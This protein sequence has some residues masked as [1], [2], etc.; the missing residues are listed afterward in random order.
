MGCAG[1]FARR[2]QQLLGEE[3]VALRTGEQLLDQ[4]VVRRRLENRRQLLGELAA[5]ERRQLQ[6]LDRRQ[7]LDLAQE[8]PQRM[9]AVK[10]VAAVG[11][12][13]Q[14]PL[15]AD[16]AHQEREKPARGGIG[17]MQILNHQ[18]DRRF[19]PGAREQVHQ[20]LEQPRLRQ[21]IHGLAPNAAGLQ[22]GQQP[23][24]L[25]TPRADELL[26]QTRLR[27]PD[28]RSERAQQR[29][30]GQLRAADV[31]T[32]TG[33]D[34][35][36]ARAGEPLEL[37]EQARLPDARL[38]AD[39]HRAGLPARPRGPALPPQ[40]RAAHSCQQTPDLIRAFPSA[41]F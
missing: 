3:R 15:P 6:R 18:H 21:R 26:E 7:P 13:Q 19:E 24:K 27:L 20:R 28:Q 31:D 25:P 40:P 36:P 22:F 8:L 38:S 2:R 10:L 16:V 14:Q 41:L 33:Q 34:P 30:V 5:A 12:D 32:A 29:R 23:T 35:R 11:G 1:T 4:R 37:D 17:P 9:A 39:E